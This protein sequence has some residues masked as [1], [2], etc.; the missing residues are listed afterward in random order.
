MSLDAKLLD[1]LVCPVTRSRL[2][3]DEAA[4]E[5]V[6][7]AAGLAFPVRGGVPVMLV[8]EARKIGE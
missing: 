8:E 5:L 7:E 2:R 4:Q 6:S 3:Y 1:K